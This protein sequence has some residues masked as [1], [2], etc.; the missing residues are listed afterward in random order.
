MAEM[1][2][3][4]FATAGKIVESVVDLAV[5]SHLQPLFFPL[6]VVALEKASQQEA[7]P[8]KA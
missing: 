6:E 1:I 3:P 5:L 4:L 8:S 7:I 2:L